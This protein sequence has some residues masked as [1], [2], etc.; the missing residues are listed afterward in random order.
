MANKNVLRVTLT[1]SAPSREKG[2]LYVVVGCKGLSSGRKSFKVEGL[3]NPNYNYWDKKKQRFLDGTYTATENNPVLDRLCV[4][5]NELLST[6]QVTTPA[7][8]VEALRAG[9]APKN[10]QTFGNYIKGIINDMRHITTKRP[11][12]NYQRYINLLHK[13]EREG[14]IINVLIS[15]IDTTHFKAFGDFI[16]SLQESEGKNNYDG[17]MKLFKQAHKKAYNDGLNNNVL[18]FRYN[19]RAPM[20]GDISKRDSLTKQ[21]YERFVRLDAKKVPQSGPKSSFYSE[22]YQDFCIFLYE[23][24]SRP[25]DV[26]RAHTKDIKLMKNL[27]NDCI[28]TVWEYV[29]EK[30]KNST[31]RNKVVQT[32]L[33]KRAL[34][35]I[36]KYKN[37]STKGYIFPFSLNNHDWDF[38]NADSWNN[39]N[40]R[41]TRALEMVNK[42][43]KKVQNILGV[44]FPITTY[45]FRRSA[46]S[47]ACSECDNYLQV[48]LDAGTSVNMLQ[49]HYVTN[50]API[51]TV[52]SSC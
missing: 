4:L 6:P 32:P 1:T 34:A 12:R 41:H 8:F 15:D 27:T 45:T 36:D 18:R 33:N 39:W 26:L 51:N 3:T 38:N 43:L 31:S 13:L 11:S 35:I 17:L 46:L 44:D 9:C 28:V 20:L 24:K 37:Q 7:Q 14:N 47:H 16:E 21:Q 42:W 48:A 25:V 49:K 52:L 23:T 40:N 29:P 22:L 50:Y 2:N 30:K 10:V 19:E 5:C